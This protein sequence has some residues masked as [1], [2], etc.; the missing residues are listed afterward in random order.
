MK[1]N[2]CVQTPH[3]IAKIT[4]IEDVYGSHDK[5]VSVA[6]L[7]GEKSQYSSSSLSPKS[8]EKAGE[9]NIKK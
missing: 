8:S 4:R 3:G 2:D 7:S 5:R 9:I 1:L 6:F